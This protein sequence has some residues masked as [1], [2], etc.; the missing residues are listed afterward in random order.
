MARKTVPMHIAPI[1]K[2]RAVG[3]VQ[4]HDGRYRLEFIRPIQKSDYKDG[5][6]V[7]QT[8]LIRHKNQLITQIYISNEA[9][10]ALRK[11]TKKIVRRQAISEL[12]ERRLEDFSVQILNTLAIMEKR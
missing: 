10:R 9:A 6:I 7:P 2:R 4:L 5:K 1:G 8:V 3:L 11:L 12:F